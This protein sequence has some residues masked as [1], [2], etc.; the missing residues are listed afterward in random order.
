MTDAVTTEW[1]E[2][3]QEWVDVL[4][5]DDSEAIEAALIPWVDDETRD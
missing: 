2:D 1:D 5:D 3:E 4:P